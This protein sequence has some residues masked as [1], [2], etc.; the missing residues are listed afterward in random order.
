MLWGF[1][2]TLQII[3]YFPYLTLYLPQYLTDF[4][5]SLAIVNFNIH[6]SYIDDPIDNFKNSLFKDNVYDLNNNDQSL[7]NNGIDSLS[8]IKNASG[9]LI[10]LFQG[11][12]TWFIFYAIKAKWITIPESINQEIQINSKNETSN[13]KERK[14]NKFVKWIKEKLIRQEFSLNFIV[15]EMTTDIYSFLDLDFSSISNDV[16]LLF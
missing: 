11:M 3:S 2:N 5:K 8:I 12:I 13:T 10:I 6:I 14:E 9:M 15:L 1:T 4:I 7:E 16:C